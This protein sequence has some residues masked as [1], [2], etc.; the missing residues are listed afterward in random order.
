MSGGME[1]SMDKPASPTARISGY[2]LLSANRALLDDA[3]VAAAGDRIAW[4]SSVRER[5][6]A[7]E[8]AFSRHRDV[9]EEPGG[10]LEQAVEARPALASGVRFL[11]DDHVTLL[12]RFA[13]LTNELVA[14]IESGDI[15]PDKVR[16]KASTLQDSVR[17]H[18]ARGADLLHEAF[19][20]DDGGEG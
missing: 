10:Q 6:L 20:R 15:D 7:L 9:S 2:D 4:A 1:D 17:R 14:L 11:R 16:W 18:M 5:L 8:R 13:D 3:L 19:V 12:G